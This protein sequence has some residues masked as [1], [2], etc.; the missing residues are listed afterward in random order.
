VDDVNDNE[1]IFRRQVYNVTLAE[2]A[3]VGHCFLQVSTW[4]L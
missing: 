2:H 1:P 3:P 4:G